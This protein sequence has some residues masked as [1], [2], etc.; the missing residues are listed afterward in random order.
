MNGC[1]SEIPGVDRI[2]A[3]VLE[4]VQKVLDHLGRELPD[5]DTSWIGRVAGRP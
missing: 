3:H 2:A 1:E 4:M 5:G